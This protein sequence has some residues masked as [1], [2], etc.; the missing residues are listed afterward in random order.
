MVSGEQNA[1][2]R[3]HGNLTTQRYAPNCA[4]KAPKGDG[5]RRSH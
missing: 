3:T 1:N 2:N 4:P 5:L